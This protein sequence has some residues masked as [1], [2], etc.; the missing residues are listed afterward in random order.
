MNHP[1]TYLRYLPAEGEIKK[2]DFT[3]CVRHPEIVGHAK[4]DLPKNSNFTKAERY[5]VTTDIEI[6]DQIIDI[7]TRRKS[8]VISR[9]HKLIKGGGQKFIGY[10]VADSLQGGGICGDVSKE[11]AF[12]ILAPISP[13]VTWKIKD[14][15]EIEIELGYNKWH[16]FKVKEGED[17][18]EPVT[19][20]VKGPC[21][22]YH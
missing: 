10:I 4:Q 20:K 19:C 6:L 3:M 18:F 14:G 8:Y 2:G 7:S 1:K 16:K 5:A 17:P 11:N 15:A 12:K 13:A 22:H 9:N 21:G